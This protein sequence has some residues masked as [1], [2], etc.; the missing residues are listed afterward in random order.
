ME[1]KAHTRLHI[2]FLPFMGPG[3]SLPLLDIAKIFASRGV[4]S[5]IITT[6]V[7]AALLSKQHRTSKSLGSGIEFLVIKFPSAK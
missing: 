1:T 5:S 2:F 3:H 4:K 6:P 7:S